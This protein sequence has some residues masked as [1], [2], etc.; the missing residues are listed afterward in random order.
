MKWL[1]LGIALPLGVPALVILMRLHSVVVRGVICAFFFVLV[2]DLSGFFSINLISFEDYR[3][4]SRGMEITALDLIALALLIHALTHRP[5]EFRRK[6]IAW[7][8]W[9]FLLYGFVGA[10]SVAVAYVPL[11]AWFGLWKLLR[12]ILVYFVFTQLIDR[13][14]RLQ[15]LLTVYGLLCC[16]QWVFVL[17]QK[18]VL[19]VYRCT[20]TLPHMN[21]LAMMMNLCMLPVF[22]KLMLVGNKPKFGHL[23]CVGAGVFNVLTTLSRGAL[24]SMIASMGLCMTFMRPRHLTSRRVVM[25][26]D[27]GCGGA[28][29][30]QVHR[31]AVPASA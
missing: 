28:R 7:D 25:L 24:V 16:Y 9:L 8:G 27:A 11:Y 29:D 26:G 17:H 4:S 19:G 1:I 18:Y 15:D 10:L 5:L 20:G 21:T 31:Y 22:A 12:G 2:N 3:G 6:W 13:R 14:E 23:F 30:P